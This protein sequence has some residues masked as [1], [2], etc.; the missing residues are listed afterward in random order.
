LE[1]NPNDPYEITEELRHKIS[2]VDC[3]KT[4]P[5]PEIISYHVHALF[6]GGNI[7]ETARAMKLQKGFIEHFN[8]QDA[9]HCP[10][11]LLFDP[12]PWQ[13]TIC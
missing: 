12:A 13:K 10:I 11:L 4:S 8:L 7:N 1:L 5:M 6:A 9:P 2:L 3:K